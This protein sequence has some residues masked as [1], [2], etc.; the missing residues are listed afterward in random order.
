MS[1]PQHSS[2]RSTE[3]KAP[4]VESPTAQGPGA[5]AP[6]GNAARQE[7]L[8]AGGHL[9]PCGPEQ[10]E[11]CAILLDGLPLDDALDLAL[12]N[13]QAPRFRQWL[14]GVNLCSVLSDAPR[15]LADVL[16]VAWP[17]GHGVGFDVAAGLSPA[18]GGVGATAEGTSLYTVCRDGGSFEVC[19]ETLLRQ[20]AEAGKGIS[21]KGMDDERALGSDAQAGAGTGLASQ[22][23]W[24]IP[25]AAF[26]RDLA[27]HGV[28]AMQDLSG[29]DLPALLSGFVPQ[30]WE[31]DL[32]AQLDAS[33]GAA[34]PRAL[35]RAGGSGIDELVPAVLVDFAAK[36]GAGVSV[37]AVGGEPFVGLRVSA[38]LGGNAFELLRRAG[39]EVGAVRAA[40]NDAAAGLYLRVIGDVPGCW[41]RRGGGVRFE[42]DRQAGATR[43]TFEFADGAALAR[44]FLGSVGS[45]LPA[46]AA[47]GG[48]MQ[49]A[50]DVALVRSTER[51]LD[52]AEFDGA[53]GAVELSDRADSRV[54]G[55]ERTATLRG[56]V[57]VGRAAIDACMRQGVT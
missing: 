15:L 35:A 37:G 29:A 2:T 45:A 19:A 38:A 32:G 17:D 23:R 21:A 6:Q 5:V 51:T 13:R 44:F 43:D 33:A 47:G 4:R 34:A 46:G 31:V 8:R 27:G 10:D 49:R 1:T 3:S 54:A 28:T 41:E 20:A 52:A 11:G 22:S 14:E 30:R 55:M 7:D 12:A 36:L 42:L 26:L 9:P 56:S 50:P 25:L 40:A 18:L 48:A 24:S 39:V 53:L 16:D 57:R